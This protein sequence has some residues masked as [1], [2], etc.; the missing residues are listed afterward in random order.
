[1]AVDENTRFQIASMSKFTAATAVGV[2]VDRGVN[3]CSRAGTIT[4]FREW[5]TQQSRVLG[6]A[7]TSAQANGWCEGAQ[8]LALLPSP[9]QLGVGAGTASVGLC[10][11]RRLGPLRERSEGYPVPRKRVN[12]ILLT[13]CIFVRLMSG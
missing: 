8:E 5:V 6:V 11:G 12:L 3:P 7:A 10:A 1:M 9:T 4:S 2:L 13:Q